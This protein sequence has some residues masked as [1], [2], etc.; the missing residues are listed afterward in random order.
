FFYEKVLNREPV[1]PWDLVPAETIF[2]YERDVCHTC[3]EA[4]QKSSFWDIIARAS[5]HG[6]AADSLQTWLRTLVSGRKGLLIS[7]HITRKDDF[8][9]VYYLPDLE[10][11]AEIVADFSSLAGYRYSERALN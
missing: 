7:A 8:D 2:V 11:A 4:L 6:K 1:R 10:N 5:L 3:I 9:F